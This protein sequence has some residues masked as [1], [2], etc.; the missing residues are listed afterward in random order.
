MQRVLFPIFFTA[1]M[2]SGCTIWPVD[3][4]P[5]G[6]N[7]RRDADRVILALQTYRRDKGSFPRDLHTLV[8]S[9]LAALPERPML[10]YHTL[11]GSLSY[12]YTPSWP[13]LRP[14]VCESVSNTTEWRCAEHLL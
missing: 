2:L 1:V 13:Q 6:M 3:Q 7:Y 4:D 8:P 11:D 10:D 14:V 12:R 9:Y 5:T